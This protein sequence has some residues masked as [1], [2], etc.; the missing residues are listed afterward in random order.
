[1]AVWMA[2]GFRSSRIA[3][4]PASLPAG[5]LVRGQQGCGLAVMGAV[6]IQI[7]R[8]DE[9]SP[10]GGLAV[11]AGRLHSGRAGSPLAPPA[12]PQARW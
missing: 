11:V 6:G 12:C 3:C 8:V 7:G 5:S 9:G 2:A 4:G 1:L 10:P